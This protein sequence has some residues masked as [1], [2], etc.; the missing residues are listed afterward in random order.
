MSYLS[1]VVRRAAFAVTS[2]YAIVTVTFLF[3]TMV[4][5]SDIENALAVARYNGADTQELLEL[6]QGLYRTYDLNDPLFERVVGWWVDVTTLDWGQSRAFDE[7]IVAVLDGRIVTTLEYVIP[8]ILIA[9]ALGILVGLYAALSKDGGVDWVSRLGSYA[10]LGV[11]VFVL[12]TYLVHFS[13]YEVTLLGG[14]YL[15]LPEPNDLTIAAIVVALSLL[16]G[17]LRFARASVLEQ[18]GEVFVKMLRAK[19]ADRLRLARHVLRNAA[20]PIVSLSI[21]ELLGVLVLNI[22]LIER[23]LEIPGLAEV[24]L[25]AAGLE[26]GFQ[27]QATLSDIPLLIWSIM[28]VVFLGITLSFLQDVVYGYLDP[29]VRAG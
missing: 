6:K 5:K 24:T 28:V 23:A 11:P 21:T 12:A 4:I 13:G 2:L 3:G 1:Y 16:A 17:Q 10:L 14:W 7:P 15:V 27:I 20:L 26:E 9:I 18:T 25:R 29:R 8:G 19:G 22:Y